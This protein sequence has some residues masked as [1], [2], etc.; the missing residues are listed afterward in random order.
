MYKQRGY[1]FDRLFIGQNLKQTTV[2]SR[3][4]K[5]KDQPCQRV[6]HL[7]ETKQ[8]N[9]HTKDNTKKISKPSI[10][11]S[12]RNSS[13]ITDSSKESS[14]EKTSRKQSL[15]N[16]HLLACND[17]ISHTEMTISRY[18]QVDEVE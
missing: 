11:M 17:K 9:N 1:D 16:I 3:Q 2:V 10:R 13:I 5:S 4:P 18:S 15:S 8:F 14:A 6:S 7:A 12:S